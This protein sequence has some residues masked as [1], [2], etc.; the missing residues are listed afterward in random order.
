MALCLTAY[1][2][3]ISFN[4]IDDSEGYSIVR[5][6]TNTVYQTIHSFG[7]SDAWS[8]QFVGAN[9]PLE[10]R[11][12]IAEL[13][14]STEVDEFNNPKGIGLS[15][16]RFNIGG[17]SIEQGEESNIIKEWR[18]A[19][20]FLNPDSTY[21]WSRQAGQQWFLNRA[22]DYGVNDLIAFVNSPP[23]HYTKNGKAYSEDG[24]SANLAPENYDDYAAFLAEVVD[25]LEKNNGL[26]I[27]YI[28]PFNEP[29]W[30]WTNRN[31]EG[32]PWNNDELAAVTREVDQALTTKGLDTKIEITEAASLDYLYANN[33]DA[34][35]GDQV[36]DFFGAKND[37]YIGDLT[38]VAK[39]VAGHSYFTTYDLD[40]AINVRRNV[41]AK[42]L[43]I[44]PDLEFWMT[45][46]C[47]LENNDEVKGEGR[48]LGI[49]PALYVARVVHTD[50]TIANAASWQWWL[51]V[52]PYD[53]KDGLVYIDWDKSDGQVY[54]SKILWA[55]GNYSKFIRPGAQRVKVTREN[56][57]SGSAM[58]EGLMQSAYLSGDQLIVVF[59]NYSEDS[60][61][62]KFDTE[63]LGGSY[64]SIKMYQTSSTR[65][66]FLVNEYE[67]DSEMEI[68]DRSIVTLIIE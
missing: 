68:D 33:L 46:Y 57:P 49:D 16:W 63:T 65:D 34:E 5:I 2:N 60:E 59:V 12:Q 26:D 42:L 36:K 53:Y 13:L 10:K 61:K 40:T 51:A 4:P 64:E 22:S 30:E 8:T 6:D 54:E 15:A 39:K 14:F 47:L 20:C 52:S 56:E 50:L 19:E 17:G 27:D 21:D 23:V 67:I 48:N 32:A 58:L 3:P 37:N 9:W 45:E 35:R 1:T 28:S 11:E 29:Q 44:D 43:E 66:L 38:H 41:A 31:Q 62:V 25:N 55:L 7:A 18:R 24:L